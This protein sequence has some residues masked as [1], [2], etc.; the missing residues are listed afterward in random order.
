MPPEEPSWEG[1]GGLASLRG[2]REGKAK[3]LR[4]MNCEIKSKYSNKEPHNIS[5]DVYQGWR[6]N[7]DFS[8][9]TG[10]FCGTLSGKS[11]PATRNLLA[12]CLCPGRQFRGPQGWA[13]P[14]ARRWVGPYLGTVL[15][16]LP[17][18]EGGA[19]GAGAGWSGQICPALGRGSGTQARLK[20]GEGSSPNRKAS[21]EWP[22][23]WSWPWGPSRHMARCHASLVDDFW[24]EPESLPLT[25]VRALGWGNA[26]RAV[27]PPC[28]PSLHVGHMWV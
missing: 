28:R 19:A 7:T 18:G 22:H 4:Y 9:D 14:T 13:R 2:E 11:V 23:T 3:T 16:P 17:G 24:L 26:H 5:K 10:K 6:L 25:L 21:G 27:A 20:A 1:Q 12:R 15:V 8:T